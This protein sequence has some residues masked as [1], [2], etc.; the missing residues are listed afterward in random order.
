VEPLTHFLTGACLSRT[1]F[2]RKTAL[3]TAAMT[4]AAEAPDADIL[5]Y[6]RGS[7][8]GF[9]HHRGFTHTVWGVP[10]IA[11]CVVGFLYLWTKIWRRFRPPLPG[12]QPIYWGRLYWF[13]CIAA[14]SHLLLDFTNNYGIRPLWPVWNHWYSWDIVF[15]IEPV[16]LAALLLGLTLPA[17]FGLINSEIGS[18]QKGPRG[19]AAAIAAIVVIVLM[20]GVRDYQHRRAVA[21]LDSVTYLGKEP[22]RVGAF[23]T[24]INPF[25]WTGVVDTGSFYQVMQVDSLRPQVDPQ[26]RAQTFFK[27]EETAALKAAQQTYLGRAYLDWST[28]PLLELVQKDLPDPGYVV[29]FRDLRFYSSGS[30]RTPMAAY[31]ELDP[32]LRVQYEGFENRSPEHG[33]LTSQKR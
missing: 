22:V 18:R 14:L 21:A 28:F 25:R 10:L 8:F 1:G 32:Q 24:I 29:R 4:L 27:P 7:A 31:V 33:R 9:A 3:A 19:R 20:W 11:A 15:I 13:S 17:F 26:D 30:R 5:A 6:F 23:P 16:M 2:N 12:A